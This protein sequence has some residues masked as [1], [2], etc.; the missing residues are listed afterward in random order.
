MLAACALAAL[1][2]AAFP[3][4]GVALTKAPFPSLYSGPGPKPGPKLLYR[5]A[6]KPAPQLR[7]RGP[8]RAKPIM[9]SGASAYR[10]GEFLYQDFLYDDHGAR[11]TDDPADPRQGDDTFSATSGTYTYPD[12]PRYAQNAADLVELRVRRRGR[13]TLFRLT[14]N[15]LKDPALHAATIAIGGTEGEQAEWPHDAGVSSPA[16]LFLTW[17]G[18]TA[19]LLTADGSPAPGPGPRARVSKRRNQVTL[20]VPRRAWNPKRSRVR[21]AAGV[22]LWDA[23]T[24]AYL[25]PGESRTATRPGGAGSLSDPPA[26]F[27]M[28]FRYDEPWPEVGDIGGTLAD[29]AWWRE[30]SQ[31]HALADGDVSELHATVDFGAMRRPGR[32]PLRGEPGG[33]PRR[34]PMVRILSSRFADGEGVDYDV[35]CGTTEF[36]TG[37]YL[38]RLQPYSVYV[39]RKP[40]PPRGFGLTLLLHSLGATYTQFA[41]S[42]NQSQFGERG[43]G[44]I[45]VTSLSRGPDGWYYSRAGA[46]VFEVWADVARRYRLDP[47]RA[48]IAGYSM[49]GYA[50]YKLATQFPDLFAAGQ[51]TVGPPGLGISQPPVVNPPASSLTTGMLPSLRHVPLMIW[52]GVFDELVPVSGVLAHVEALDALEYRYVFD[53]FTLTDHFALA[54]NDEYGPAAEFLG[55]RRVKR[56]PAHVTYVR[57]PSMDFP[58]LGTKADHAYWLSGIRVRDKNVNTGRGTVDAFSHAFGRGDPPAG[59]TQNGAGTLDGGQ[60]YPSAP[61]T[62]QSRAWG[63]APRQAKRQRLDITLTNIDRVRVHM[64]RARLSCDARIELEADG[65]A[66]VVLVGCGESLAHP[67]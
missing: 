56:N 47:S 42:A 8:W 21:L 11:G 67:P 54:V 45:V 19:E 20:R 61:Y 10:R 63:R 17:H 7:N 53:L 24:G 35:D 58:G 49:G 46:D 2:T 60:L 41:D 31:A 51:P 27:N 55:D 50:T 28:A 40:L 13:A 16:E 30:R 18:R 52:N 57:N 5:D 36:C 22:G 3:A 32:D 1:G 43:R 39:P 65:E 29:A 26:I 33:I 15:T 66:E 44:H 34:G 59:E 37:Q 48:A 12:D 38:G 9:V 14:L 64:R 25:Q 62:R 4:A 6:P 23:D